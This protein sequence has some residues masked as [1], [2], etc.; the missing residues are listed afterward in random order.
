MS[1]SFES[2]SVLLV[3]LP[4]FLASSV[5]TALQK[6]KEST[7]FVQFMEALAFSFLIQATV[8]AF[9][10]GQPILA[11]PESQEQLPGFEYRTGP[12][13]IAVALSLALPCVLSFLTE[14]DWVF[15]HARRLRITSRTGKS[16][17]WLDLFTNNIHYFVVHFTDGSRA[18]GWPYSYSDTPEEGMLYLTD[19]V[20]VDDDDQLLEMGAE[21]LFVCNPHEVSM[22]TLLPNEDNDDAR[23]EAQGH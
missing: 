14:N 10:L 23:E 15:R 4:G 20:W 11:Q 22:I 1:T 5:F 19:A 18:M 21:G 13:L 7:A 8:A 2:V 16:S 9:G 17:M 12:L 3:L 6:R